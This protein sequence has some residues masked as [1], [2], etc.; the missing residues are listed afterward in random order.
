MVEILEEYKGLRRYVVSAL[1]ACEEI[2]VTRPFQ[3][4]VGGPERTALQL[5]AGP[6]PAN[7]RT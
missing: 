6:Y 2:G 4:R 5:K 1:R 3:A 7:D